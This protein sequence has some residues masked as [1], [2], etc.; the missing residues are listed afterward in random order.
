MTKMEF[1]KKL[2]NYLKDL[3]YYD[4][5]SVFEFY[6]EYFSD[7]N[8]AEDDEIPN[9]MNPK[10][11]SRDILIDFGVNT[12]E[13]NKSKGYLTSILLFLAG[14]FSAPI[15]IFLIFLLL[16]FIF[17]GVI[18]VGGLVLLPFTLLWS[19]LISS[20]NYIDREIYT[21]AGIIFLII[22]GIIIFLPTIVYVIRK[23]FSFIL[24][25][26]MRLYSYI[27]HDKKSNYSYVK[28]HMSDKEYTNFEEIKFDYINKIECKDIL[29]KLIIK[30][31]KENKIVSSKISKEIAFDEIYENGILK[32]SMTGEGVLGYNKLA[33]IVIEYNEEN[34]DLE[35]NNLLGNLNYNFPN[36]GTFE[37]KN[38]MGK[39]KIE[40]DDNEVDIDVVNKLGILKI[41]N[42]I[43]EDKD[44]VRKIKINSIFGNVEIF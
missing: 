31:G 23:I 30:K 2:D 35:I 14:I 15:I 36:S 38:I 22:G 24:N 27:T 44:S 6:E 3:S 8:I 32:L 39:L 19:I 21:I 43:V 5:K 12:E 37:A 34:L 26:L 1:M 16:L 33:Y 10:K 42:G 4:K 13:K 9:D 25:K 17:L 29:G 20:F 7:L 11:I 28:D 18:F 40:L 41:G